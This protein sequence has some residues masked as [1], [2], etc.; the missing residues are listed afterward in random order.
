[1]RISLSTVSSIICTLLAVW[2][3]W[4]INPDMNL[5]NT[6]LTIGLGSVI[7]LIVTNA[8][9]WIDFREWPMEGRSR[10]EVDKRIAFTARKLQQLVFVKRILERLPLPIGD[11]LVRVYEEIEK[12]LETYRKLEALR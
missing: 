11:I 10:E 8:A 7:M 2:L 3:V 6:L 1:M 12:E 4:L 5:P 9:D